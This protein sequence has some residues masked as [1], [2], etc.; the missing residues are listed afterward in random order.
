MTEVT[1][2]KDSVSEEFTHQKPG[3]QIKEVVYSRHPYLHLHLLAL[4]CR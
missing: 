2:V 3:L 1:G 4:P